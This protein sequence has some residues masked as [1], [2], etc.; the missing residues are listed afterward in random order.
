MMNTGEQRRVN[1][2]IVLAARPLGKPKTSDFRL[3]TVPV[4]K[5]ANGQ[6]LLR[7]I[8]LSLDP[9]MRGRMN[10]GP[11]YAA[12]VA[13]ND[14]LVG[15]TVCRVEA[16]RHADFRAGDL[17]L[18]SSG[19]QDY[20]VFDG[21]GITKLD[22]DLTPSSLALGVLGM[23]GFTAYMGL[24]D[25]GAPQPG[26]TVVVA[27]ATGAVGS[28]VGQIARIQ[29][30]L[31]IGIAGGPEK[32][33]YAV[34]VLGFDAC[35]DHHAP[36]L[37]QQL[38]EACPRGIDVYFENVGGDVLQAV[39]PLL[40]PRARIPLCGLIA[41]Y[42]AGGLPAGPDHL[43]LLMSTLLSRRI[44]MQGFII[45]ADYGPRFGEFFAQ[46]SAWLRAGRITYR[47][48][49]VEGLENAPSAFM[50]LLEGRN[51][52]KLVVRVSGD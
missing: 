5:P 44:R 24:L 40:N 4:P 18:A 12:Q 38:L 21:T 36:D 46:M 19:W 37:S 30:S 8:F 15:G 35:I 6:V 33:R 11:S 34:E 50:G 27:A 39:L 29:G 52:G 48:D 16:S 28:V 3:E 1:R 31:A 23:P 49:L 47:E 43:P 14:V 45:F 25:I 2:R 22:P 26:E 10:D 42:N 13:L 41:H 17:V 51:F 20:A 7:T 32:C 9:Y